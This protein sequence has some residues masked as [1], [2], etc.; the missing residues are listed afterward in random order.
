MTSVAVVILNYNGGQLLQKFLPS[1]VQHCARARIVVVDN[2]STDGSQELVRKEFPGIDLIQLSSNHGF[3]GG[4]NI[5]LK[6]VDADYYVLLN[7]DVEVTAGWL[8]PLTKLLDENPGAAAVQPKILSYHQ[9][10]EFEY[11]G[12]GGGFID[13]MGYPFCRGRLFYA[14]EEDEGQYN[15]ACEIFWSSGACMMVRSKLFHSSGGFDED[16]FAHMEEI[17][18]CWRLQRMGHKIYYEGKS[19]VYHV[20]GGTLSV[21]NPMKTY[22]NFK[23][24]LSL[25]FK[26]LPTGEL[27]LK[28][29]F[30]I[31]LDWI[32][33][34]KFTLSGSV[35]DGQA[36]IRAHRHFF[37]NWRGERR[38]RKQ[39]SLVG[40]QKLINQYKG[41]IV[42]DFFVL[43]K[44]KYGQVKP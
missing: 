29:P 39:T 23:N 30:R 2:A 35:K 28:F 34:L 9:K 4:Y 37:G 33:S 38:R 42:W 1:V 41:L 24:G 21:T 43:G 13:A 3:C 12:A 32:A 8:D 17:D 15:D 6:K 5:G 14:M 10:K 11:A 16:F 19:T 20:G 26:N 44:R 40:Y 25:L 7:S 22:L 18:L 36:V 31:M 27:I